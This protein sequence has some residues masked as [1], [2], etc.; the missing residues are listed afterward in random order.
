MSP[1]AH[2]MIFLLLAEEAVSLTHDTAHRCRP[3]SRHFRRDISVRTSFPGVAGVDGPI[4]EGGSNIGEDLVGFIRAFPSHHIYSF[5]PVP[6]LVAALR[7]KPDVVNASN[8]VH[9]IQASLGGA[10]G[11][12]TLMTCGTSALEATMA[13]EFA[14]G[15]SCKN[16]TNITAAVHDI[17]MVLQTASQET[18]KMPSGLSINCEG[19]EYAIMER[20]VNSTWLGQARALSVPL[21]AHSLSCACAHTCALRLLTCTDELRVGRTHLFT[22]IQV[23]FVLE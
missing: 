13:T 19:C 12:L 6:P 14:S 4:I 23:L 2:V 15:L 8:R 7:A 16:S 20:F 1:R 5:E 3:V 18:G 11:T 22:Y 10:P 17:N 21:L 9:I